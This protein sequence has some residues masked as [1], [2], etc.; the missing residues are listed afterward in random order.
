[1]SVIDDR[2]QIVKAN[3]L[4]VSKKVNAQKVTVTGS[5]VQIGDVLDVPHD[6]DV[7]LQSDTLTD[8][9]GIEVTAAGKNL[10]DCLLL[11]AEAD[12]NKV[13]FQGK[14]TGEFYFSCLFDYESCK[15]PAAAQFSFI[16]DGKTKY[17][18]RGT[19]LRNGVAL[20]GTLTKITF[21]N[22]GYGVGTVSEIQLEKGS[23]RTDYVDYIQPQLSTA[24][25]DG[26]VD[27]LRTI[28]PVMTLLT[29]TT[30]AQL[31]C[32]YLPALAADI[33]DKALAIRIETQEL[34]DRLKNDERKKGR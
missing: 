31:Q 28:H 32:T 17:M 8:F 5:V 30:E 25:A 27:G 6:L 26:I 10:V 13:L 7:Q 4:E 24:G 23:V 2:L 19:S 18:T 22:W 21:I 16:V 29:N 11:D 1:M 9:T 34:R 12:K 33:V 15:T 20:S 3:T 14:I